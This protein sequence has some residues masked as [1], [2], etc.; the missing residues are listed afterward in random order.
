LKRTP[1]F[2]QLLHQAMLALLA[3]N[4]QLHGSDRH[5]CAL[6]ERVARDRGGRRAGAAEA[7]GRGQVVSPYRWV[8]TGAE[9]EV[10][11]L[12]VIGAGVAFCLPR[13]LR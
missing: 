12:L 9:E 4:P 7:L 1:R 2:Y 13:S 6:Q 11:D 3:A 8:C 10:T 5:H